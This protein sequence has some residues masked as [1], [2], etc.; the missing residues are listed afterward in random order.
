MTYST[1]CRVVGN[2]CGLVGAWPRFGYVLAE[3]ELDA[4]QRA[5]EEQIARAASCPSA[6]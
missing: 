1:P 6:A 2:R 5:L 4:G 3:R